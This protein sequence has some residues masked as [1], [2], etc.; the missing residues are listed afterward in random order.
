MRG[1]R[2]NVSNFSAGWEHIMSKTKSRNL[3]KPSHPLDA[4]EYGRS[5]IESARTIVT[6]F[7]EMMQ[8][9]RGNCRLLQNNKE[10][11]E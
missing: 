9:Y 4:T 6:V 2:E 11:K 1:T 5:T 3:Q 10:R 7:T 8:F